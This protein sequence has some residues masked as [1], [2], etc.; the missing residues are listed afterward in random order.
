MGLCLTSANC[1]FTSQL[2]LEPRFPYL[3]CG[4]K[5]VELLVQT[6]SRAWHV[7]GTVRAMSPSGENTHL[8]LILSSAKRLPS[9]QVI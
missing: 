2:Q 1:G 4:G 8:Y 3:R 9:P 7:V 6:L 5:D